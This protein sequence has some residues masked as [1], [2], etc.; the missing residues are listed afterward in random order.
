MIKRRALA[1]AAL[2]PP[3]AANSLAR[4]QGQ[5][6]TLTIGAGAPVTT[7]DPHFHNVGPNN[8]LTM[9]IFDRLVE[10]DGQ[11]R[12]RPS[13]AESWRTVSDTEWEFKLRQGVTWHDGKPF[14]AD[15]VVFT[16]SRVPNV[17]NSPGGF[18]GFLRAIARV[19]VISQ[20]PRWRT[21]LRAG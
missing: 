1:L 18:G 12:M 10:R 8:A 11:S 9:H 4:A 14:T 15:D 7:T 2:L 21:G 20:A 16:F 5:D 13:L 3:V 17:P 6:R 19:E